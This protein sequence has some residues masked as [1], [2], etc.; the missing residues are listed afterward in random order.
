MTSQGLRQGTGQ[1]IKF[2]TVI[3]ILFPDSPNT[4]NPPTESECGGG[5]LELVVFAL[6]SL[7][8]YIPI[9]NNLQRKVHLTGTKESL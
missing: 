5:V 9:Q 3:H 7:S 1:E 8:I 2:E 6:L 4:I